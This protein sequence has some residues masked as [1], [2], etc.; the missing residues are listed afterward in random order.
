MHILNKAMP[1]A[2]SL[3]SPRAKAYTIIGLTRLE[4]EHAGRLSYELARSLCRQYNMQGRGVEV[5]RGCCDILQQHPSVV[6]DIGLQGPPVN[7][8][9]WTSPLNRWAFLKELLSGMDISSL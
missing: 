4:D 5:V 3:K 2:A 7:R 9:S 1:H 8:G 6:T